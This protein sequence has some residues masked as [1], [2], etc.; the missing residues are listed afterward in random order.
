MEGLS[1]SNKNIN[2][3][4]IL[5]KL[6]FSC[7]EI[8]LSAFSN[9]SNLSRSTVIR[10]IKSL[11]DDICTLFPEKSISIT[12]S[13]RSDYYILQNTNQIDI[14]FIIDSVRKKYIY[15]SN[16]YPVL[17][18][19]LNKRYC[20]ANQLSFDSNVSLSNLYNIIK[21][22]NLSL[23]PFEVSIAFNHS[24]GNFI[25][26]EISIR[27]AVYFLVWSI[28][29]SEKDSR[30]F[31]SIPENYF[32]IE[33]LKKSLNIPSNSTRSTDTRLKI[34]Q[35]ISLN[36]T[37]SSKLF[38]NLPNSF[39][40]D[41]EPM[42]NS[43]FL[44]SSKFE[45][46]VNPDIIAK[47]KQHIQLAIRY[48]LYD[49]VSYKD[50]AYVVA[51]YED[52]SLKINQIVK[53]F[54]GNFKEYFN[55]NISPTDYVELYYII[56]LTI[57]NTKY[58]NMD[59]TEPILRELP[60]E[61]IRKMH[62]QNPKLEKKISDFVENQAVLFQ[63]DFKRRTIIQLFSWIMFLIKK[64]EPL[65]I[66]VQT[67]NNVY[68]CQA[69]IKTIKDFIPQDGFNFTNDSSKLDLLITDSYEGNF[70]STK[71]YYFSDPIPSNTWTELITLI[72]QL[73]W[74]KRQNCPKDNYLY[75]YM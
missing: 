43:N 65:Q 40:T 7:T 55:I 36:R 9:E 14:D 27:L 58:I 16:W 47:E 64:Y 41:I 57:I 69:I 50:K 53:G 5:K 73:R 10:Y 56:L 28:F 12:N 24:Q 49:L 2:K 52:S 62:P 37:I 67:S 33:S 68:L 38:V 75:V 74:E 44:V 18:N 21:K 70:S 59:I 45:E 34:I 17:L 39:Y 54:I 13:F 61:E 32:D 1:L 71:K 15:E 51:H 42:C 63:L 3:L 6:L 48:L 4:S 30:L 11:N 29:R 35:S 19:L 20:S 22:I 8:P 26:N 31:P 46:F 23:E 66:C 25:G 60:I 72:N